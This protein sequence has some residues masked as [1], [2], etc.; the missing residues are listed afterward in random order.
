MTLICEFL[1][2]NSNDTE[3]EWHED[4]TEIKLFIWKEISSLCCL[5][6]WEFE[7]KNDWII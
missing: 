4:F 3:T 5:S 2:N 1:A 6:F 7:S